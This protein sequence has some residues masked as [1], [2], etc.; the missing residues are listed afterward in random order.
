MAA[1]FSNLTGGAE[2]IPHSVWTEAI[3]GSFGEEGKDLAAHY[4]TIFK[5]LDVDKND[6]IT[7]C[8][9]TYYI[10]VCASF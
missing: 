5:V 4:E 9:T 3:C 10:F 1:E 6:T 2:E 7:V 8:L